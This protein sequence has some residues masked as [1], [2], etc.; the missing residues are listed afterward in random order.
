MDESK[1]KEGRG[2]MKV[3]RTKECREQNHSSWY[4]VRIRY[5]FDGQMKHV[6]M[7]IYFKLF[8]L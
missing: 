1:L 2:L 5:D 3:I 4:A 6:P 7:S 8:E